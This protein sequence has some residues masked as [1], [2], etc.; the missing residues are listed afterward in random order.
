[1]SKNLKSFAYIIFLIFVMKLLDKIGRTVG[2]K[3]LLRCVPACVLRS[4]VNSL[5]ILCEFLVVSCFGQVIKC[6]ETLIR[7]AEKVD[8]RYR[9]KKQ[10][11]NI[12]QLS[13]H[14]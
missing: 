4:C 9:R 5:L 11:K 10:K 2:N 12:P 3:N 6:T 13:L 7:A 1:M 8:D 14:P